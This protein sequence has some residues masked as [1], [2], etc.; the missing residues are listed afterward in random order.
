MFTIEIEMRYMMTIIST[1]FIFNPCLASN[2]DLQ[3]R[4]QEI[5]QTKIPNPEPLPAFWDSQLPAKIPSRLRENHLFL[6]PVGE[7]GHT[8]SQ[9]DLKSVLSIYPLKKLRFAGLLTDKYTR[10]ALIIL[11]NQHVI[12]AKE[13]DKIGPH[14]A[15]IKIIEEQRMVLLS[16]SSRSER[17][18]N[19]EVTIPIDNNHLES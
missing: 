5:K 2:D 4:I 13:G 11:P 10:W 18:F 14:G 7:H 16:S 15:L 1:L 19:K 8:E 3:H 9:S 17:S 6:P 12:H